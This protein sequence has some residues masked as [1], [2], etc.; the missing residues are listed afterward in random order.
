MNRLTSKAPEFVKI[1][2]I[3]YKINTNFRDCLK[4]ILAFEDVNLTQDEQVRVLL[5]NLYSNEDGELS[6]TLVNYQKA[7][8]LGIKFLDCGENNT[9]KKDNDKPRVYSFSQDS[10]YINSAILNKTNG[11][12]LEMI[13]YLHWWTFVNYFMDMGESQFSNIVH[14]REQHRKGKLTKEEKQQCEAIGWD[15]I[16]LK[17]NTISDAEKQGYEDL[18]SGK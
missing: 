2:D 12:N 4:I 5:Y 3:E 8:E 15:V 18:L 9:D 1:D 17:S 13:D 6:E 10:K 14:L 11:V 16:K 7:V